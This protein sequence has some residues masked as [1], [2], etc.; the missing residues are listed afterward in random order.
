MS[1]I[2]ICPHSRV[3]YRVDA[4]KISRMDAVD[5]NSA[6]NILSGAGLAPIRAGQLHL[7]T[8]PDLQDLRTALA[9]GK[10]PPHFQAK[11]DRLANGNLSERYVAQNSHLFFALLLAA[12][13]CAFLGA[14]RAHRE[15]LARVLTYV[16]K[17]DDAIPDYLPGGFID[18]Q[19]EVKAAAM[20][21]ASLLHAFKLWRLRH[22]VPVLW[23]K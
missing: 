9:H 18:D 14:T 21:M 5:A 12:L 11:L 20:E 13:D 6:R 19:Q 8:A 1:Q 15:R 23:D 7:V 16:N 2:V 4:M 22:Q 17:E 10:L 3:L